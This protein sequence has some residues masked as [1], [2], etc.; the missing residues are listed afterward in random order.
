MRLIL[1]RI[2]DSLASRASPNRII[3]VQRT[4]EEAKGCEV[5]ARIAPL[6][7]RCFMN[8]V[9]RSVRVFAIVVG[10][11]SSSR[12]AMA[13][14]ISFENPPYSA[15]S[16]LI[17]QDGWATGGYV[18]ADPFFGGAVNGTVEVT[19][20]NPLAGA[21]SVLYNQT[22]SPAGAGN[23]GASDVGKAGAVV[24]REHGSSAVDLTA[25]FL[26][27]SNDNAVGAP[28][29][30]SMGFFLGRGG[31]SPI[32]ILLVNAGTTTGD[33]LVGDG[34]G[35]PDVGDFDG[36]DVLEFHLGVDLDGQNYSVAVRNVTAGTPMTTLTG[37]GPGGRFPFF[38]GPI[39]DDGD[40]VTYTLDTSLM[41]RSGVGRVDSIS[42]TAVP[43]PTAMGLALLSIAAIGMYRRPLRKG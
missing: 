20:T 24:A 34:P 19:A 30:G 25:S 41:L 36:N 31:N 14:D 33:I 23:T 35:L 27:Q 2:G 7:M 43:E 16:S 10:A 37:T 40:G 8:Y 32:L 5:A 11:L 18:L 3:R 29:N 6:S 42:A 13:V 28:N 4:E 39:S 12:L 21:Q 15:G 1:S 17:G 26:I 38:G 22:S 9:L